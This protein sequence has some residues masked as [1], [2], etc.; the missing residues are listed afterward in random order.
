MLFWNRAIY[1]VISIVFCGVVLLKGQ[2]TIEGYVFESGNRGFIE[3][4]EVSIVNSFDQEIV[5]V[6][7]TDRQGKYSISIKNPG[8]YQIRMV[9][10]PYF[11]A[12]EKLSI[13]DT[14]SDVIYVKHELVR[15]PGYIFD[16]TLAEKDPAPGTPKDALNG[17][18]IEVYNNTLKREELVINNLK[19]PDFKIDLIKGNHYTILIRKDGFLSKRLEAFVDVEGCI[20]CFEG[21]GKVEP[22]VSDNLTNEN[23]SGT[24]LANVEL[25]RYFEGKVIELNN[26][27]YEFNSSRLTESAIE[28]LSKVSIFLRDNPNLK[29]ELGSHTDSRGKSK[30]NL[31]LSEKRAKEAVKFLIDQGEI[32]NDLISSKG[33]GESLL[34]NKCKD[35]V[36]CTEEEHAL[37]RR[38]ELKILEYSDISMRRSL[39]QMKTE[40]LMEE[41]LT[42]ISNSQ[43]IKVSDPATLKESIR[44]AESQRS[45]SQRT[46]ESVNVKNK[47]KSTVDKQI[48]TEEVD[49]DKYSGFRVVIHFSRFEL[50]NTHTIFNEN[51]ELYKYVTADKNFLYMLGDF[52][53]LKEAKSYLQNKIYKSYPNAYVV[54]FQNGIITY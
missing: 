9:K 7:Q 40:E 15:K 42:D 53:T 23:A 39:R 49:M 22:G 28:E 32:A 5:G 34:T 37:N 18:L 2:Y 43:Q 3:N 48:A 25:D 10:N 45:T 27:Y 11:E 1:V 24:L 6:S 26:I 13:A 8:I 19:Q 12:L 44:A 29:I 17:A 51:E 33:Y 31:K 41:I 52:R 20:L 46:F 38:T 35:G 21:V 54:G 36:K 30:Q 50:N 47:N 4:A 16:I 14:E